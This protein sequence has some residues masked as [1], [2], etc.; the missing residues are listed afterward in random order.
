[1]GSVTAYAHVRR[2]GAIVSLNLL[3]ALEGVISEMPWQTVERMH[4]TRLLLALQEKER[5]MRNTA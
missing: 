5:L 1:M 2:S 4:R 3:W